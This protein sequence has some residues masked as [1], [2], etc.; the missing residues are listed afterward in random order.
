MRS[1]NRPAWL[2]KSDSWRSDSRDW[3][4]S[5]RAVVMTLAPF[6]MRVVNTVAIAILTMTIDRMRQRI[7]SARSR[8]GAPPA[9]GDDGGGGDGRMRRLALIAR[10][11]YERS[12]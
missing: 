7:G 11:G 3:R 12:T 5:L 8:C 2:S 10:P 4:R 9:G 6:Q 1:C